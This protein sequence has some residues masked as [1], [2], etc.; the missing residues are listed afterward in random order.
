MVKKRY[1][2]EPAD[3]ITDKRLRAIYILHY[4]AGY[5]INDLVYSMTLSKATI[6]R[7]IRSINELLST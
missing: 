2:I 5:T 6:N 1:I 7:A 3:H 4:L